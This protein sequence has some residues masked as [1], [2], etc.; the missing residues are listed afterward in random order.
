M[1]I[2][3]TKPAW[4]MAWGECIHRKLRLVCFPH[5]GGSALAFARWSK[6]LQA[7]IEVF[8]VQLPGRG[9]RINEKP[10]RSMRVLIPE[11]V[12][13]LSD[14]LDAPFAFFGHSMGALIAFEVAREL[15][16]Q[17]SRPST[18]RPFGVRFRRPRHS[19]GH[20]PVA[21]FTRSGSDRTVACP[22]RNCSR[23]FR[24]YRVSEPDSS[25][26][27]ARTLNSWRRMISMKRLRCPAHLSPSGA[28][29]IRKRPAVA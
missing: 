15:R 13:G 22:E 14:V 29:S 17:R 3:S 5:A 20:A 25:E 26:A 2:S 19:S 28:P 1:A 27:S 8:G 6:T 10:Y 23:D 11:L 16:L 7:G 4:G 9:A 12:N 18:A 21:P 24:R